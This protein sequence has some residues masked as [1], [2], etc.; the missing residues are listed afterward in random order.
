MNKTFGT[1]IRRTY[2]LERLPE[3]L[4]PADEHLQFFDNYIDNTRLRL[5]T[6]RIPRASKP[7]EWTYVL[8]QRFPV[9]EDFRAWNVS[10]IY[11]N[12]EEHYIF[13]QFEGREVRSNE[14]VETNELRFN[15]YF[16]DFADKKIEIDIFLQPLWGLN[17]AKVY[18][19]TTEEAQAF[20]QPPFAVLEVTNNEFFFGKNLVGK[21][22]ADIQAKLAEV[23]L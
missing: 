7:Q 20:E 8:E 6:I 13:E 1:E 14:R 2:L 18:F 3:P 19:E 21:S 10:E 5:R 4:K 22:I 17:I 15:R 9:S 12:D 23:T 11:L 16:L